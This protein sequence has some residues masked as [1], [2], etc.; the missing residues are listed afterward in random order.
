MRHKRAW[1]YL[2]VWNNGCYDYYEAKKYKNK[3]D[4]LSYFALDKRPLLTPVSIAKVRKSY[5]QDGEFKVPVNY[6]ARS[7]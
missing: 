6:T 4:L 2:I 5:K 7:I 1:F 3:D